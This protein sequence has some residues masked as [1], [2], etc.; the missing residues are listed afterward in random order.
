MIRRGDSYQRV[1]SR[2]TANFRC[3][4]E[5]GSV[6]RGGSAATAG[7]VVEWMK[8]G[9]VLDFRKDGRLLKQQS[10]QLLTISN[11]SLMDSGIYKC[12]V[13]LGDDVGVASVE[14]VVEGK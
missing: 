14:L 1:R 3:L 6:Q 8:D 10:G 4:T 9:E 12:T 5:V 13:R 2:S 11:V 7:I